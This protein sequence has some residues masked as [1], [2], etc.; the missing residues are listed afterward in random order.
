MLSNRLLLFDRF[1]L[2][3][4]SSLHP[5]QDLDP[6]RCYHRM[7]S[8]SPHFVPPVQLLFQKCEIPLSSP[9]VLVAMDELTDPATRESSQL[10]GLGQG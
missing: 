4:L 3:H 9:F 1:L 5:A 10:S 2:L 7:H 6:I 8:V